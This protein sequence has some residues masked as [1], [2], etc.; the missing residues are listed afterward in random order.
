MSRRQVGGWDVGVDER[1]DRR[2]IAADE[3]GQRRRVEVRADEDRL[4]GR[5]RT[6]DRQEGAVDE[7]K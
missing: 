7:D 2:R 4:G 6:D 3:T 5:G 1:T